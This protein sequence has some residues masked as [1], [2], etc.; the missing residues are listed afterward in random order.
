MRYC[1]YYHPLLQKVMTRFCDNALGILSLN[2]FF[3]FPVV[4]RYLETSR[5]VDSFNISCST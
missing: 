1:V 4:P 3:S 5:I 2:E